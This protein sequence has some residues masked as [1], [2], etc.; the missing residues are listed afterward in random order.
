MKKA[1]EREREVEIA[2]WIDGQ[3][4]RCTG[5]KMDRWVERLIDR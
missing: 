4:D 3:M 5:G 1:T 2:G